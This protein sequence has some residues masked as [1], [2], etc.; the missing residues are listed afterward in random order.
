MSDAT[1][2]HLTNRI[3]PIRPDE[4]SAI[5][6]WQGIVKQVNN[7]SSLIEVLIVEI[8]ELFTFDLNSG[9]AIQKR[10]NRIRPLE[11]LKG[12]AGV[13]ALED[14]KERKIEEERK[15]KIKELLKGGHLKIAED[16]LE[17]GSESSRD[18]FNINISPYNIAIYHSY[19][20]GCASDEFDIPLAD[21]LKLMNQEEKEGIKGL[22]QGIIDQLG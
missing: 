13:T 7:D 18:G 2:Q 1:I 5:N 19:D 4:Y 11:I 6:Y 8:D 16:L 3:L 14:I 12:S 22:L 21:I 15:L 17:I 10:E 20:G 9:L